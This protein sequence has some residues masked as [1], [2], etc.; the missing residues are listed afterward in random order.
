[1]MLRIAPQLVGDYRTAPDQPTEGEF[2]AT[3]LGWTTKDRT[4]LGHLGS[5]RL[6][7]AEKG[8][9]LFE[10]FAGGVERLLNQVREW[11]GETW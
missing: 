8:E 2:G 7:S 9:L 3:P 10:T 6:A 11:S 5:P 1:M 4:A